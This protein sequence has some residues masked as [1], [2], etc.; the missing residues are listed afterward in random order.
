MNLI[1]VD[2]ARATWIFPLTEL[3]PTGRSFAKAFVG[4]R[5]RYNFKKYPKHSLDFDQEAKGLI[6][7]EGDF[8]NRNGVDIIVKLS[9][10]GMVW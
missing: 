1:S 9:V 8:K 2:V 10:F 7:E 3:N 5:E 6:F 4:L